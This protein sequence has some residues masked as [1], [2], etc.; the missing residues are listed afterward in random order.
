[1]RDN[2]LPDIRNLYY[3]LNLKD[4]IDEGS[5]PPQ[6]ALQRLHDLKVMQLEID[7]A[8]R[9]D[10]IKRM[11]LDRLQLSFEECYCSIGC[12]RKVSWVLDRFLHEGP[13]PGTDER[14]I[15]SSFDWKVRPP[16][17]IEVMGWRNDG[18]K[19]M[20][21]EKLGSLCS[22]EKIEVCFIADERT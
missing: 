5:I 2:M 17:T 14:V 11:T 7:W 22:P 10:S 20:I 3:D 6:Q 18:E 16:L 19:T 4:S 12:C 1:M 13:P 8:E 9:I 21:S 15:Y